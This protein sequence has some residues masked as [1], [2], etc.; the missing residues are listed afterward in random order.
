VTVLREV[1]QLRLQC[2]EWGIE[3]D[4]AQL[5]SLSA[6]AH[7]L[8][9]YDLANV[10]G[11]RD[12][13]KILL[14]HLVDA[15]SCLQVPDLRQETSIID[16]GTGAGLPGIPLSIARPDLRVTLL[17]AS[18]KKSCFLHYVQAELGQ[19]NLEVVRAR[20]EEAGHE[21]L[22]RGTF[23]LAT[24]RA[25]ALLPVVLEYCTPFVHV[26][27]AIIAMKGR[28]SEEELGRG[29]GASYQ[30]GIELRE[31]RKVKHSVGFPQKERRLVVF[32]K[33]EDTPAKFPRRVG[34]A[35]KRPLGL[36]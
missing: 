22:H 28:L 18:E 30:L 34:L 6:F 21:P 17:E 31:V 10:I 24:A 9:D 1:E 20:A 16:V 14:D 3:L 35:K 15:L 29:V 32:D 13:S 27:G 4:A 23:A 19:R 2:S 8:A 12:L 36:N 7:L 26:G 5:S 25:L 11:T 33:V